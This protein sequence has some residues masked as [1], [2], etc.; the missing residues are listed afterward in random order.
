MR[1]TYFINFLYENMNCYIAELR[2]FLKR[3]SW[4]TILFFSLLCNDILGVSF[5]VIVFILLPG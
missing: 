5:L 2:N 1:K 3:I 4:L